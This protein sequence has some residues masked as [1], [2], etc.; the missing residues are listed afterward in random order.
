MNTG[1]KIVF[2]SGV[3]TGTNSG[4]KTE[5]TAGFISQSN[6][7]IYSG[8]YT[9]RITVFIKGMTTVIKIGMYTGRNRGE[10]IL[11]LIQE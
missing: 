2:V 11:G 10:W 6:T 9:G 3:N 4:I 8:L 7:G 1:R 5:M